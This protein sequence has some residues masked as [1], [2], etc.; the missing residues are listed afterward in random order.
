MMNYQYA[1]CCTLYLYAKRYTLYAKKDVFANILFMQ[2]KPNFM[3]FWAK[4]GYLEEKQTQFKPNQTQP[5]VS[6]SNLFQLKNAEN[7][8]NPKPPQPSSSKILHDFIWE[9]LS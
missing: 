5:V 9:I 6:L 7:K 1:I 3:R 2:N 8:P 4:N